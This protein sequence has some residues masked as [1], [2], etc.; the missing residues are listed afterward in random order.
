MVLETLSDTIHYSALNSIQAAS[1]LRSSG[2]LQIF[3]LSQSQSEL[4]CELMTT[5]F[6]TGPFSWQ[7]SMSE[8]FLD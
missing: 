2:H 7:L 3:L 8:N 4:A 1:G 6:L 5:R